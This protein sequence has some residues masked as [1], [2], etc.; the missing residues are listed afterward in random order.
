M[1]ST[2]QTPSPFRAPRVTTYATSSGTLHAIDT[3]TPA[4]FP[5]GRSAFLAVCGRTLSGGLLMR[6]SETADAHVTCRGCRTRLADGV[7]VSAATVRRRRLS[8][9]LAGR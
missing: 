5:Q 7:T 6:S 2:D 8:A 4:G 9:Q 1:S 3:G